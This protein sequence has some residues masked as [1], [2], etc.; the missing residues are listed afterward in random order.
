MTLHTGTLA[1]KIA[2]VAKK[3][4][5]FFIYRYMC[6]LFHCRYGLLN[7]KDLNGDLNLYLS[8]LLNTKHD[9]SLRSLRLNRL[10][11]IALRAAVTLALIR[12]RSRLLLTLRLLG[13]LDN[14][15]NLN[16]LIKVNSSLFAVIRRSSQRNSLITLVTLS[17]L[18]NSSVIN[19]SL[20]LLTTHIGSYMR[21]CLPFVR[22]LIRRP[23]V[24]TNRGA[25]IG[26]CIRRV[27]GFTRM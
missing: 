13:S 24:M 9:L 21:I 8:D 16:R 14:G 25:P 19:N 17:L 7:S 5:S 23:G 10:L 20:M 3:A 2:T 6:L 1:T 27:R 15:L 11:A 22:R 18:S 4:R 26:R 12:L